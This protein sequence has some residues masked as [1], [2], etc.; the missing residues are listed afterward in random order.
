VSEGYKT[1]K[2]QKNLH[3]SW[4]I[5]DRPNKLN[6]INNLMLDELSE[7]IDNAEKDPEVGCI[8]VTGSGERAFNSG[9]DIKEL[10]KLTSETAKTFSVKGQQVFSKLEESSKPVIAAINGYSLGGGL[11]LALACDFRIAA[12]CSTFGFPEAKLGFIPGWGATQ[13][14]PAVVGLSNAKRLIMAGDMILA[15]EAYR[16]G[17]V[18]KVVSYKDLKAE[19]DALAK[20]LCEYPAEALKQ[21]KQVLNSVNKSDMNSGFKTETEAFGLLF[22]LEDTKKRVASFGSQRNKK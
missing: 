14:L 11:E 17:L 6:A 3:T 2:Q 9:A 16:I 10:Q 5:L 20:K 1:I 12:D 7:A 13:R 22:S 21:A 4:I 15:D 18:D 8:I 19:V